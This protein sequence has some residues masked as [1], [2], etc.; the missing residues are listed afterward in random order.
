MAE[1]PEGSNKGFLLRSLSRPQHLRH[2]RLSPPFVRR[3]RLRAHVERDLRTRVPQQFLHHLDVLAV[4][5]QQSR[6]G[7][8]EGVP[9]NSP[10]DLRP[11]RRRANAPLQDGIGTVRL[12]PLLS[13]LE[14]C[15]IRWFSWLTAP[16]R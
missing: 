16:M 1:G 5:F 2:L 6:E 4:G 10:G 3:D 9:A 14:C 12:L 8:P 7:A 15:S 13:V 11:R